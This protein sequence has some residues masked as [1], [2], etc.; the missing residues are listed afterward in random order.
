MN[1]LQSAAS[2]MSK[3]RWAAIPAD[4]R[5]RMMREAGKKGGPLGGRPPVILRC[6][7]CGR[8]G[9]TREMRRHRC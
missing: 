4:E 8:E 6:D 5:S 9:P 1:K 3:K 2:L 7:Q